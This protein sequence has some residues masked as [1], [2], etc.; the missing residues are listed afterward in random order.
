MI[1]SPC[2][3]F[4]SAD[5]VY[6]PHD[7][8]ADEDDHADGHHRFDDQ[9]EDPH[10]DQDEAENGD[11]DTPMKKTQLNGTPTGAPVLAALPL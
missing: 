3:F 1:R 6:D 5:E 8:A 2:R 10:Q 7:E 9:E 4:P 11:A